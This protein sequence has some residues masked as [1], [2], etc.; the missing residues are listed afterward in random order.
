MYYFFLEYSCN[1]KTRTT[2]MFICRRVVITYKMHLLR[3]NFLALP[4]PPH[5]LSTHA[6]V[7]VFSNSNNDLNMHP[8]TVYNRKAIR[9][10]LY[11]EKEFEIKE[12]WAP[13]SIILIIITILLLLY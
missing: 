2:G 7:G 6:R 13:G 11:T 10:E 9:L 12:R 3:I 5:L 4:P 1:R 8:P